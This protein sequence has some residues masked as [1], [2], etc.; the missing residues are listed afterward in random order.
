MNTVTF[1]QFTKDYEEYYQEKLTAI[2]SNLDMD[3]VIDALYNIDELHYEINY[4][5]KLI[6][7][8]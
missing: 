6:E 5:N 4:E 7:L 1:K 2:R 3:E 8:Y